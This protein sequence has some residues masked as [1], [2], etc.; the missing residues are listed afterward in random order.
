[1]QQKYFRTKIVYS[2]DDL[3]DCH[4]KLILYTFRLH[5]IAQAIIKNA[6]DKGSKDNISVIVIKFKGLTSNMF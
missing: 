6:L 5:K 1:M 4:S 2:Y 3:A